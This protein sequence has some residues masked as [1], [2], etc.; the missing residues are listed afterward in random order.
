MF[1]P[2]DL[3]LAVDRVPAQQ[4]SGRTLADKLIQAPGTDVVLATMRGGVAR[5][6]VISLREMLP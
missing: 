6:A 4:V 5:T 3:I 2:G 1:T